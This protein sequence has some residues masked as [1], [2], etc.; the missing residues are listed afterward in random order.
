MVN[1]SYRGYNSGL[2]GNFTHVVALQGTNCRC[3]FADSYSLKHVSG[4][5]FDL[6]LIISYSITSDRLVNPYIEPVLYVR[7]SDDDQEKIYSIHVP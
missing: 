1:I 4:E 3:E 6:N 2:A 7:K 5:P